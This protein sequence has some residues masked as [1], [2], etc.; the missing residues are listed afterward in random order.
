MEDNSLLRR[1]GRAFGTVASCLERT[2]KVFLPLVLLGLTALT[3]YLCLEFIRS[4]VREPWKWNG[5]VGTPSAADQFLMNWVAGQFR[6]QLAL[7]STV[8]AV[9]GILVAVMG[10]LV[11]RKLQGIDDR[12]SKAERIKEDLEE[13]AEALTGQTA[14]M[15][16]MAG[17]WALTQMLPGLD[18]TQ[19]IPYHV[20][21]CLK[22]IAEMFAARK[23][24]PPAKVREILERSLNGGRFRLAYAMY[25]QGLNASSIECLRRAKRELEMG[26]DEKRTGTSSDVR[27]RLLLRWSIVARQYAIHRTLSKSFEAKDFYEVIEKLRK[28]IDPCDR[29]TQAI[30]YVM[31]GIVLLAL[32]R[33][34]GTHNLKDK[35]FENI[36][37][38]IT[39]ATRTNGDMPNG[40]PEAQRCLWLAIRCFEEALQVFEENPCANLAT[41]YYCKAWIRANSLGL[42]VP[43]TILEGLWNHGYSLWE[44]FKNGEYYDDCDLIDDTMRINLYWC[45]LVICEGLLGLVERYGDSMT[46]PGSNMTKENLMSILNERRSKLL[47]LMDKKIQIIGDCCMLIDN[48]YA[49]T[50]YS[51]EVEVELSLKDFV[52][53]FNNFKNQ[54]V[55]CYKCGEGARHVGREC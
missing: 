55:W 49:L 23:G 15:A 52:K 25:L 38:Q 33:Q 37:S 13:T 32:E 24:T 50:V 54:P 4:L 12:L 41:Y 20:V 34:A 35:E 39:E 30:A 3:A 18:T 48:G 11:N 46:L 31:I 36:C 7:L 16:L 42:D 27:R 17:D 45:E 53:R 5:P 2:F 21:E 26:L 6:S 40:W 9:A 51:E 22:P 28:E 14:S 8:L 47:D 44:R 19:Q 10:W 1:I 29:R 43:A